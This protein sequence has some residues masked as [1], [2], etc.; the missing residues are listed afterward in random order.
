[1]ADI[2]PH[3]ALDRVLAIDGADEALRLLAEEL[4]GS[5]LTT[6][7]LEVARRRVQQIQPS[8][9]MQQYG[10]DRF[11]APA[12][13]DPILL[14]T[15]HLAA[16]RSARPEYE[17][18]VPAPLAP[19]GT[20]SALGGVHQNN[21][22][23]AMRSGEVAADPTSSLALEAAV[24]R[25]DLLTADPR[26]N[27]TVRLAAVD[28]VL[29]AQVF[30]GSRSF[31]HFALFGLVA[32]GRDQGSREFE[33]AALAD[34]LRVLV[35]F[36]SQVSSGRVTIR[37]TDFSGDFGD[38]VDRVTDELGSISVACE[39]WSE[40]TAGTGYYPNV[41]F[42]LGVSFD[43]EDVEIADG[44]IVEWTQL[45]LQNRKE[46]LMIAGLSLERLALLLSRE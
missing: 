13:V 8:D 26:S 23:T 21:V 9:V 14:A 17:P 45:L 27:E 25:R 20:H 31:A 33:G 42:K 24:R 5:D 6:L 12:Q 10:R 32:A 22:V 29:R 7:L 1:M 40:R 16:L 19:L 37:L 4:S 11:V 3:P 2:P 28:R 38:V 15:L 43:R 46:R 18:I 44:G 34:Q 36:V 35:D 39:M 30:E 41:C